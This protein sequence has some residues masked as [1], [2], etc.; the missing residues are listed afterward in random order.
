[1]CSACCTRATE[2]FQIPRNLCLCSCFAA[3][4]VHDTKQPVCAISCLHARS[5]Y[6]TCAPLLYRQKASRL[7]DA[8]ASALLHN[9]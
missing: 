7:R 6:L 4:S 1:M 9:Q 8:R 3:C 2:F 5:Q